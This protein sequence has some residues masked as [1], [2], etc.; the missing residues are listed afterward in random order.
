MT[1]ETSPNQH[2]LIIAPDFHPNVGGYAHATSNFVKAIS[3]QKNTFVT[4]V[5]PVQLGDHA[6]LQ[7]D[8]ITVVRLESRFTSF[9]YS[10]LINQVIWAKLLIQQI[11][12][13]SYDFILFETL[14]NP[15]TLFLITKYLDKNLARKIA[16][17]IH[18]ANA[19]E[20][21]VY[22]EK[23]LQRIYFWLTKCAVKKIPN[24]SATTQYYIDFFKEHFA[25]NSIFR[26]F[27]N[28][29][30][31]PNVSFEPQSSGDPRPV[32]K[33]E[34]FD[35]FSLG[36]LNSV[37]YNQKNFELILFAIFLL[38]KSNPEL[39]KKINLTLVG[40]GE[41]SEK[42]IQTIS[43]LSLVEKVKLVSRLPHNEV[44]NMQRHSDAVVLASRFEGQSMFALESLAA[45]APLI[46]SQ[47][48]GITDLVDD[49]INGFQ[50]D[51]DNPYDLAS[52]IVKISHSNLDAFREASKKKYDKNFRPEHC[53]KL[54]F[55]FKDLCL[56]SHKI[57]FLSD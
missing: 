33:K 28:Y 31:I 9:R 56:S 2:I 16:I 22:G 11:R 17:R 42:I 52:A 35:I 51:P 49:G 6:E 23:L 8:G 44:R 1:Q 30:V 43:S 45:G 24:I 48:T 18:A 38:G 53:A 4:V 3:A 39:Y 29:S 47:G 40:D 32:R 5:T 19:T 54:F 10:T 50:I 21:V 12:N 27:K 46:V 55:E 57:D 14:E 13:N 36:R 37:G 20:I 25:S 34:T 7:A 26:T 15:I 41:F